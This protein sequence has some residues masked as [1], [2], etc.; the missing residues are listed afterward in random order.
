MTLGGV[1]EE[2]VDVMAMEDDST[3]AS[4]AARLI[5]KVRTVA[6]ASYKTSIGQ[7]VIYPRGDLDN[8]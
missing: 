1:Q 6:A 5:S 3:F 7:P 4:A 2:E 8:C